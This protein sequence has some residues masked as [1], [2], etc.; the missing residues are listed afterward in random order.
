MRFADF[1]R[2]ARQ[3]WERIPAAYKAGVDGLVVTRDGLP[4]PTLPDIYTL[5]ECVTEAYP[6]DFAGPETVRSVLMLYHGS[7]RRLSRLDP[8][9]DWEAELWETITHELRHH[10]E[11]LAD[12]AALEALDYA[13]DENFKRLEGESFDPFFYRSGERVAPGIYRVEHDFFLEQSYPAA[14]PPPARLNFSW[15]GVPYQASAP[16]WLGDVCF[17]LI[18]EGVDVGPGELSLVLVRRPRLRG[19]LRALLRREALEV[20]EAEAAAE[21]VSARPP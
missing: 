12:E 17:L 5:G 6:S 4:H 2:R 1:E 15:H 19:A 9:F 14:E 10:L 16:D 18:A 13:V 11:G 20:V 21:P 3:L 8:E 7:F